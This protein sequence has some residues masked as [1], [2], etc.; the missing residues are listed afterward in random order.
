[1]A[2]PPDYFFKRPTN[3]HSSQ[4]AGLCARACESQGI[5][6]CRMNRDLRLFLSQAFGKWP[7]AGIREIGTW[8]GK[9]MICVYYQ[10]L[11]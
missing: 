11:Y 1:M 9:V 2:F 7:R 3:F 10:Y 4:E 8:L 6:E 5:R